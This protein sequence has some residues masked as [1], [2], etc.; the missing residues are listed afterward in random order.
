MFEHGP[1]H[2]WECEI[3]QIQFLLG[4][5]TDA[6]SDRF[7]FVPLLAFDKQLIV[8]S[9]R[10]NVVLLSTLNDRVV[11]HKLPRNGILG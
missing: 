3:E 4:Q 11:I 1:G 8:D 7:I 2:I 5:Q 9:G 6:F 10:L